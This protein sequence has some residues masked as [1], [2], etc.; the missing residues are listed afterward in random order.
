VT[1]RT[2]GEVSFAGE[3][4][5]FRLQ[6]A[7]RLANGPHVLELVPEGA[8]DVEAFEVFAPPGA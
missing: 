3:E 4:G 2:V 1:R 6:L 8:I 5:L 7:D